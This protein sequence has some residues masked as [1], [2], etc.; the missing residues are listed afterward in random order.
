MLTL[1]A[2]IAACLIGVALLGLLCGWMMQRARARRHLRETVRFW[3]RRYA[4]LEQSGRQ[5]EANLEERLQALGAEIRTLNADNR[6]LREEA[7]GR[8]E[9]S[10]SVRAEAIE[11]NRRQAET[12]ER[13]QRIIREREREIA[14]LRSSLEARGVTVQTLAPVAAVPVADD[15]APTAP[16]ERVAPPEDL[17]AAAEAL[18]ETMRIDPTQLPDA[19]ALEAANERLSITPVAS[20][21]GASTRATAP[22]RSGASAEGSPLDDSLDSTIEVAMLDADEAT[23]ALDDETLALVRGL[24]G[25]GKG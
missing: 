5:D 18:D 20:V 6:A 2:E 17:A 13:L 24:G 11:Q 4:E 21:D 1:H 14:A 15:A 10:G 3:E 23:V 22:A 9:S 7:R 25:G 8:E 12:Q 19:R 16:I